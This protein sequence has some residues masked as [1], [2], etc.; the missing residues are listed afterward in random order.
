MFSL[1]RWADTQRRPSP[2]DRE[3]ASQKPQDAPNGTASLFVR[4]PRFAGPHYARVPEV[5][6]QLRY[7][8]V[9]GAEHARRHKVLR[10]GRGEL[11]RA[12]D[13]ERDACGRG[14]AVHL[15]GAGRRGHW[16]V[17]RQ[18]GPK[19]VPLRSIPEGR[20]TGGCNAR[21]PAT[22]L[23]AAADGQPRRTDTRF[24]YE[25]IQMPGQSRR[26]WRGADP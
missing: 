21:T 23:T 7:E 11:Q 24:H 5:H 9:P 22:D 6:V 1:R 26:L 13:G 12:A 10:G 17:D 19:P 18:R 2:G 3:S 16:V 4:V 14:G 8:L 20:V 15:R 25:C